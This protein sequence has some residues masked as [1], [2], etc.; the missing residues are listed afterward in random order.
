LG[1][2]KATAGLDILKTKNFKTVRWSI[3]FFSRPSDCNKKGAEL[4]GGLACVA[5]EC[6]A[7]IQMAALPKHLLVA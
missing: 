3:C 6:D 7:S 2:P 1:R 4:Q 5:L